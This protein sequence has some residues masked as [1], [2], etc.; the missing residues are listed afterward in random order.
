MKSEVKIGNITKQLGNN[1][2]RLKK[3]NQNDLV[4]W[5]MDVRTNILNADLYDWY[6]MGSILNGKFNSKDTDVTIICKDS[7]N[8]DLVI[9]KSILTDACQIGFN[10]N[11]IIDVR[12]STG[13]L[14]EAG[15]FLP[16][17]VIQ[18][19]KKVTKTWED[20]HVKIIGDRVSQSNVESV[21]ELIDGLY[22][23]NYDDSIKFKS[24]GYVKI[25]DYLNTL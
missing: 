10:H 20:G 9:L 13:K 6:F 12:Q 1:L 11:I 5:W 7:N 21:E 25:D 23:I 14:H 15:D 18:H 4:N 2:P 24:M 3:A 16:D 22:K 8:E 17:S 19:W